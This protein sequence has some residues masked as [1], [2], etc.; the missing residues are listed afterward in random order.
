MRSFKTLP[1]ISAGVL[2][3]LT[4]ATQAAVTTTTFNVTASVAANCLVSATDLA[5]GAFDGVND[6]NTLSSTVGVRCTTGTPYTVGLNVGT[7]GGT[8]AARTLTNGTNTLLYNLYRNAG[9]TEIWGDGTASTFTV[10]GTG[11]GMGVP[12]T[13]NHTV[14]G[15]LPAAGNQAAPVSSYASTIQVTVTY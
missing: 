15:L 1:G 5:F 7:G 4:G 2:L 8:F 9:R 11:A 10:A 14:F 13:V 3:A 6:I 12:N